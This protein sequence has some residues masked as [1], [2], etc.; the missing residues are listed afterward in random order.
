MIN[1][2][3]VLYMIM[4]LH[5]IFYY[6]IIYMFT[7]TYKLSLCFL[8]K[9]NLI[10]THQS[11]NTYSYKVSFPKCICNSQAINNTTKINFLIKKTPQ[12]KKYLCFIIK[13][14]KKK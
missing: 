12:T 3:S 14:F 11:N 1:F 2:N 9:F 6:I 8:V 7:I 10:Y 4:L 5:Y 13:R